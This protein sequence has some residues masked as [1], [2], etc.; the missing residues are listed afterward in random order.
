MKDYVRE[1]N[2]INEEIKAVKMFLILFYS[3]FFLYEGYF[4]FLYPKCTEGIVGLPDGGLRYW[5]YLIVI[6]LLPIG[7]YLMRLGKPQAVKYVFTIVYVVVD[8]INS[9]LIYVTEPKPIDFGNLVELVLILFS[10][11]F[12]NKKYYGVVST[13]IVGKYI[14]LS[15]ILKQSLLILP[16]VILSVVAIVSF[17]LLT[18]FF[19]YIST[20][21]SAVN[22]L[23]NKEK[24]AYIGQMATTIGHEIRNPLS[25]LKGFTQ[26]QQERD[27]S[28]TNFYPIMIDEIDRINTIVDDLM[29]LGRPKSPNFKQYDL[30]KIIDYVSSVTNQLAESF[31]SKI[32]VKRSEE[33]PLVECNEKQIKQALLNIIKNAIESLQN[34]GM[35][36]LSYSITGSD[37]VTIVVKDNGCGIEVE[38]L[39]H[40]FEPFYTTKQE[41]TGMGLL[42][43]KKIIEDHQGEIKFSSKKGEGTTVEIVLP[44]VHQQE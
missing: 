32:V 35:V 15:L 6:A 19:S 44:F 20:V 11:I 29:I 27:N 12:I 37:K 40:L 24:L 17:I 1:Q 14:L 39:N 41:G 8:A 33:I 23:H 4:Y 18:R 42:I 36:E 30:K 25:S 10:P 21:T 34:G 26:L 43:T 7:I 3:V 2:Y 9:V 13:L 28:E 5:L 31:G 22:D 16:T 38:K